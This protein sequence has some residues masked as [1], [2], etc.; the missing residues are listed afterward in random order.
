MKHRIKLSSQKVTLLLSIKNCLI[1][2]LVFVFAILINVSVFAQDTRT[3]SGTVVDAQNNP[4]IG[5]TVIVKDTRIGVPTD[6]DGNFELQI[7]VDKEVIIISFIGMETQEINVANQNKVQVTLES[8][9]VQLEE[10]VVVGYGQQKKE[11]VVGAITQT[12]GEVLQRSAGI[13]DIGSALT[14]N[15]PGVITISSS[16]MPGEE[17]PKILIRSA[18]SWNNSE[19]LVLVDGVERPL[20]SVDINSVASVSVLKDAS[21]TAVFGVKGAN[22]VILITTKRGKE[23][24]ARIDVSANMTMKVPSKLPNKLDSYDALAARNYAIEHELGVY[25]DSWGY[26]TPQ[27]IINKYRF[28]ANLEESERYPNIDWQD[29]LFKDYAMS[30]NANVNVSGG[31]RFVK[32]FASADFVNEGDLF[33]VFDN[34]RNYDSGYSYNRINVRSNLDFQLTKSTLFRLNLAGSNGARKTPWG[35]TNSGDWAVAQQ[36]AGAYNIAPD[37]F[38]P[39]YSDGSWGFYPNISN[40]S[41]SAQNLSLSGTML[42]TTTQINTDF[43]LEQELDFITKGLKFRG[44]IS[45]DN[46][47]LERNRG[48]NDLYNDAQQKWI[49]PETGVATYKKEYENNNKFDFQQ[50]VLWNVSAGSVQNGATQRN[51]EYQLQLNWAREF[52]KHNITAMGLFSRKERATGSMIPEFREDWAFRTTYDF[53]SKY[54]LEYNGAYNGSEKFAKDYRF[55]FFNSGAIGWMIS[56]ES[57]MENLSFLDMLK[58]RASYGEIGDDSGGRWLYLTQ[59]AYGGNSSLDLNHGT[60]PYTWY[61]ESTVGNPDVR[62]ETVKKFNSG[63]DYAFLNGLFAGSIEY[64]VDNRVDILIRGGDRAVPSYYGTTPPT[65][66]LGKVRTEGYELQLRINKVLA[67]QVRLWADLSMTH[68]MNEILERDDPALYEDYRKQAG[69]SLGQTR[70]HVDAGYFNTYDALYGSPMHDTNDQ[71]KVPGDYYILD[72]NGDGVIDSKDQIPWGYSDSPQNTYNATVGFEWKGFSGFVQFYGVNNV[73]RNVPLTSFGSQLNTVYDAGTW[74]SKDNTNA[75]VTVPRWL[76]RPSYNSGTQY[77]YDGSYV[78][79][80]NAEIAYTMNGGW[81]NNIGFR[82]LKIFVNGNNLWVWS[83]MPDDRESNFAGSGGQ[84]AYPT[85]KRYNLGIRFTL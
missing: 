40:V 72:F 25:P 16:G 83:K 56:E 28:P 29:V 84:G 43:I 32:Y 30:Y 55:A 19:P 74:W 71:Y 15:L 68:A 48:I 10:T 4:V 54:F 82:S 57:F 35:Q 52:G 69:Y 79:L 41:N 38:L 47:F 45:W 64:F 73:T 37:V 9:S 51:L 61:R 23:G 44:A 26:M 78:R 76:S 20:G 58:L 11:S 22:G 60:S 42:S 21:A 36:W 50:G 81:I 53:A 39:Q 18:S 65:A 7:P 1:K 85:L 34:G 8:S 70:A 24:S 6:V 66:N 5:A 12:T 46:T 27:D 33:Y 62:W 67:N 63:L 80:K 49:D 14:G 3:L 75:D 77:L 59:W 31:T 2:T 13:T 17:D